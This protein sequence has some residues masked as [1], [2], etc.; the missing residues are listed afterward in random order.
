MIRAFIRNCVRGM[1]L[2]I[3]SFSRDVTETGME[4]EFSKLNGK[5]CW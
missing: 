3:L 4:H 5:S 2:V 1:T